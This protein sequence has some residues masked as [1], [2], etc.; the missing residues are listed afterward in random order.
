[1]STLNSGLSLRIKPSI[2]VKLS[3]IHIYAGSDYLTAGIRP[4]QGDS[5]LRWRANRVEPN[6]NMT[7]T[8]INDTVPEAV[9]MLEVVVECDSNENCY[10][11]RE[12]YTITI[13]DDECEFSINCS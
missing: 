12:S 9:E 8:I 7:I 2:A 6:D 5:N 4:G 10:L 1:M 3:V 13:V 11:P